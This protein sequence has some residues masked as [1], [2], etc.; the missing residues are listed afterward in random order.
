M[1]EGDFSPCP[2]PCQLFYQKQNCND[3][4]DDCGNKIDCACLLVFLIAAFLMRF[5]A[6][7][8]YPPFLILIILYTYVYVNSF[9]KKCKK[10]YP[11]GEKSRRGYSMPK[12][13]K[14]D[15]LSTF[16]NIGIS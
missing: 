6:Q 11:D 7:C 15:T 4:I 9:L 13:H 5:L 8:F 12:S 16:A 2:L 3:K 14:T 10:I 1:G